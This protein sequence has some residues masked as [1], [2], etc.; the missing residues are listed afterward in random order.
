MKY[1]I[2]IKTVNVNVAS[3]NWFTGSSGNTP[4]ETEDEQEALT[5]YKELLTA[6]PSGNLTLVQVVP[7]D[8]EVTASAWRGG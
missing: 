5:K 2:L 1:R 8:T 3:L 4:W 7:M 6:N